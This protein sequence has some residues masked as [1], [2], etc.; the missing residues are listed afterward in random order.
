MKRVQ[1]LAIFC[2]FLA[3]VASAQGPT[4]DSEKHVLKATVMQ[5][6][7]YPD[8]VDAK[9]EIKE[10]QVRAVK[11]NKRVMLVFGG[12]WCYDC[13]VLDR[14]SHDGLAGQIFITNFELV[15]VNIG[16][17]DK[18]PDLATKYKIPLEKGVPAI[19]ILSSEGKLIYSSKNQE[20]E[21]ARTLTEEDLVAFLSKW[22]SK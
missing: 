3:S 1:C 18:N 4:T 10:A 15:H 14:A 16:L 9:K 22:K 21:K 19:A 5:K 12:N 13:Y 17:G 11:V 7:L 6:N 20:F 8:G 2:L